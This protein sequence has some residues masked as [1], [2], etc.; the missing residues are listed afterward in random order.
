LLISGRRSCRVGR[1]VASASSRLLRRVFDAT[2]GIVG[3]GDVLG[4]MPA[5]G[6]YRMVA[7][8]RCGRAYQTAPLSR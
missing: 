8:T 1:R 2:D 6:S 7:T 5:S 4:A 3:D